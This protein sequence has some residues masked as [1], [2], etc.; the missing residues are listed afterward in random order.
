MKLRVLL[1]LLLLL[2]GA[3]HA[4]QDA[5]ARYH[6]GMPLDIARVLDLRE[7]PGDHQCKVVKATMTYLDSRGQEHRLQYLKLA[8]ECSDQG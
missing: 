4:A 1:M 8:Q 6:Y 7:P 5:I 2:P 3:V